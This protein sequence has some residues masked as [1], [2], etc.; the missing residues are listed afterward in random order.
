MGTVIEYPKS[1]F[2]A[3]LS[4]HGPIPSQNCSFN[5][6]IMQCIYS[7]IDTPVLWFEKT[8][9]FTWLGKKL[10]AIKPLNAKAGIM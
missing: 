5:F 7:D 2:I 3:L 9:L 8:L 6:G 10:K 1:I 4:L